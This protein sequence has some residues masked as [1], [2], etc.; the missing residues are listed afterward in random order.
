MP[1]K[2]SV[3]IQARQERIVKP[4]EENVQCD[5]TPRDGHTIRGRENVQCDHIPRDGH[6]IRGRQ[7]NN[8]RQNLEGNRQQQ[9]VEHQKEEV[10]ESINNQGKQEIPEPA[11]M[12]PN[13]ADVMANQTQLLQMLAKTVQNNPGNGSQPQ[14]KMTDS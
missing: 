7:R 5:H 14:S 8:R 12:S 11:P 6:T 1:P 10:N 4:A 9:H 2:R 13:L 3:R